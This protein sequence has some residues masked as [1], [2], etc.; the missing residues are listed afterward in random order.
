MIVQ[1]SQ[2]ESEFIFILYKRRQ[3]YPV[4]SPPR[5]GIKQ[6]RDNADQM[7]M[8]SLIKGCGELSFEGQKNK[9]SN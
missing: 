5:A 7:H 8:T 9:S 2:S 3:E 6:T 1:D 4:P